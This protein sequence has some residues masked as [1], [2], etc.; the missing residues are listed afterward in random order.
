MVHEFLT[1]SA[2]RTGRA[3]TWRI[4]RFVTT[5]FDCEPPGADRLP[6]CFGIPAPASM[7]CRLYLAW[8][9]TDLRRRTL[10]G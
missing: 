7:T 2:P 3:D 4:C 10:E 9:V 1:T 8:V 5:N 6:W